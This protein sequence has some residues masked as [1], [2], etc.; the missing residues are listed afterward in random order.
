MADVGFEYKNELPQKIDKE[1]E[2]RLLW[3]ID[4]ML[5]PLLFISYGLQYYDKAAMG[6]A[7]VFGLLE[8]LDL[9]SKRYSNATSAFYWGYITSLLVHPYALQ[10]LP[11]GKY[12]SI[13]ILIWGALTIVTIAIHSYPGIMVQRVILGIVE[14]VVSP[15]FVILSSMWYKKSEQPIR[16]AIWYS[17]TGI[18]TIFSGALN[19]GIGSAAS[20]PSSTLAPWKAIYVFAGGW[21]MLHAILMFFIL[22][23][24]PLKARLLSHQE[25][26]LAVA[27]I[28]EN[29][30]GIESQRWKWSH[31]IE[32]FRDPQIFAYFLLSTSI[33]MVNGPVTAFGTQIIKSFGYSSL[34]TILMTM[35]GG[36]TTAV[37]IW[38]TALIAAK[39]KNT[40]LILLMISCLPVIVGAAIVWRGSWN[41]RGLPLFGYY[42]LPVSISI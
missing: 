34:K 24:N 9:S 37:S 42:L 20:K 2:R 17:S 35:P 10:K 25:R 31:V 16:L 33:Y 22:P 28:R 30:T 19:Y 3:K 12:L 29:M 39:V 18:F 14:A 21:T 11:I 26:M 40:R 32:C 36:A 41:G 4:L 8:D 15:G 7:A 23:D 1:V 38:V 27:R 13:S 5:M 6:N